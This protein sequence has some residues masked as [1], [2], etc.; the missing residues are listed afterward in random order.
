MF[1]F[2]IQ[3]CTENMLQVDALEC[4]MSEIK[5]DIFNSYKQT[6]RKVSESFSND[7]EYNDHDYLDTSETAIQEITDVKTNSNL[8]KRS[9]TKKTIEIESKNKCK[10]VRA[11]YRLLNEKRLFQF[12]ECGSKH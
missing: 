4:R 3:F 12:F 5:C 8:K 11:I 2:L 1:L 10:E 9:D 7:E 6:I